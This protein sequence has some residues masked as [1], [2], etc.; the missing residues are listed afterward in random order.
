[1]GLHL[2]TE[3]TFIYPFSS[4]LVT[5]GRLD[6]KVLSF[7]LR[8]SIALPGLRTEAVPPPI[9]PYTDQEPCFQLPHIRYLL[10]ASNFGL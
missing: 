8:Y 4:L 1:M 5:L 9:P 2:G 7:G 6:F 3:V 10:L